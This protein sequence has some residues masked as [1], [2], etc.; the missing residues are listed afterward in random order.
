MEQALHVWVGLSQR[1]Y[2]EIHI[3]QVSCT[4]YTHLAVRYLL[5]SNYCALVR[6]IFI[7]IMYFYLVIERIYRRYTFELC[8]H[9]YLVW[10]GQ[11]LVNVRITVGRPVGGIGPWGQAVRSACGVGSAYTAGGGRLT[12]RAGRLTCGVGPGVRVEA[13]FGKVTAKQK[14]NVF[15]H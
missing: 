6:T 14:I 12:A 9:F 8:G 10:S 7:S 1:T 15:I 3:Y 13:R 5:F 2:L 11:L 4:L